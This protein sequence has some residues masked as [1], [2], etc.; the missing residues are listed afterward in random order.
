M[1]KKAEYT[2]SAQL[3][4]QITQGL[5]RVSA[6]FTVDGAEAVVN[7]Q[8]E[9]IEQQP[10]H[11]RVT[12]MSS[13]EGQQ[14]AAGERGDYSW[15]PEG[16]PPGIANASKLNM[17]KVSSHEDWRNLLPEVQLRIAMSSSTD[18]TILEEMGLQST[19]FN[20]RIAVAQN[21]YTSPDILIKMYQQEIYPAVQNALVENIN[22]PLTLKE[23]L[24]EPGVNYNQNYNPEFDG[25]PLPDIANKLNMK[26][27][28]GVEVIL[29]VDVP[30][31]ME[32]WQKVDQDLYI[33][34]TVFDYGFQAV[35]EQDLGEGI[36]DLTGDF[37]Y[38]NP[39]GITP[40]SINK[41]INKKASIQLTLGVRLHMPYKEWQNLPEDRKWDEVRSIVYYDHNYSIRSE[42]ESPENGDTFDL[43][44]N[45]P[46]GIAN[47]LNMR[48]TALE[49]GGETF[50]DALK[51]KEPPTLDEAPVEFSADSEDF[52]AGTSIGELYQEAESFV[53]NYIWSG[54]Q[55][56]GVIG[57]DNANI[58]QE[59]IDKVRFNNASTLVHQ[60]MQEG[61]FAYLIQSTD[62]KL[63]SDPQL[64]QQIFNTIQTTIKEGVV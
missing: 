53:V 20:V 51:F 25:P 56:H 44:G 33:R 26:K 47:K 55:E 29:R 63:R 32:E 5:D 37:D 46:E 17:K 8:G 52:E 7:F 18:P 1:K 34:D 41:Q 45:M 64:Q 50:P 58:I 16:P 31:T 30:Y 22:F 60:L 38:P 4:S 19:D 11:I 6:N 14:E 28:A 39:G 15:G 2:Y 61:W 23:K 42:Q 9:G 43:P 35:S 57:P 12:P 59:D 24:I 36:D 40:Y 62:T 10:Y 49:I 3:L 13:I 54:L 27:K 21:S 48:K